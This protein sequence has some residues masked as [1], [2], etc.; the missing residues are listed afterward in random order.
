[1]LLSSQLTNVQYIRETRILQWVESRIFIFTFQVVS[2]WE[3]QSTVVGSR[4]TSE[5]T[6][7][8]ESSAV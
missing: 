5:P 4:A 1:M 8:L 2:G 3:A 6:R 7:L